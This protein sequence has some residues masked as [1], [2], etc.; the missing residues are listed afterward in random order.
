MGRPADLVKTSSQGRI[1]VSYQIH[2]DSIIVQMDTSQLNK[3][4]CREICIMNEQGA[5][6]FRKYSD[7]NGSLMI[8]E[9]ISSW[10][11]VKA[12]ESFFSDLQDRVSFGLSKRSGVDL[13]LGRERFAGHLAW[14][15]LA[16]SLPPELDTFEYRIKLQGE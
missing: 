5:D 13:Y 6:F 14:A 9:Q 8:D 10:E 15:G 7:T 12:D 2:G 16:Y 4:D 3:T 1:A 11:K